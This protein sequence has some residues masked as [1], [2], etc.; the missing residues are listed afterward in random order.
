MTDPWRSR[1]PKGKAPL[2]HP[3]RPGWIGYVWEVP[4]NMPNMRD[5]MW[6]W[7][8]PDNE[9]RSPDLPNYPIRYPVS[10]LKRATTSKPQNQQEKTT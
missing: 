9:G 4:W 3:H 5:V 6:V 1:I 8:P 10:A 2:T 7:A